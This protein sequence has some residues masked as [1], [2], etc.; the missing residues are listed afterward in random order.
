VDAG[1]SGGAGNVG[2]DDDATEPP[3]GGEIITAGGLSPAAGSGSAVTFEARYAHCL[4]AET[5]RVVQ[6]M[7]AEEVTAVDPNVHVSFSDG[8]LRHAGQQCLP[9]VD[10]VL[11]GDWGALDCSGSTAWFVGDELIV[12]YALILD[13]DAFAGP[14]NLFFDAKGG[15]GD[16]EPRLGWTQVGTWTVAEDPVDSGNDDTPPPEDEEPGP[17]QDDP[18]EDE[19]EDEDEDEDDDSYDADWAPQEQSATGR[20]GDGLGLSCNSGCEVAGA[21]AS[22]EATLLVLALLTL[23]PRR[24]RRS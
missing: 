6:M 11:H 17:S 10:Q 9:G 15:S 2:D 5:F 20:S 14:K 3:C 1:D 16:P 19:N 7:V 18:D 12:E 13:P 21:V 24:R 8:L 23:A 22:T 4:G